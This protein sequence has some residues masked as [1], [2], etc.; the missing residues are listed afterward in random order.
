[1]P[2]SVWDEISY[3]I[4]NFYSCTVVVWEWINNFIPYSIIDVITYQCWYFWSAYSCVTGKSNKAAH[5]R[6]HLP[7]WGRDK[8]AGVWQKTISDA[9]YCGK[10]LMGAFCLSYIAIGKTVRNYCLT[11]SYV[12]CCKIQRE[13]R[14]FSYWHVWTLLPSRCTK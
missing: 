14:Q 4:P 7:A 9:F 11:N 3:P 8:M 6:L 2:I 10:I 12:K 1:M 13:S 5:L